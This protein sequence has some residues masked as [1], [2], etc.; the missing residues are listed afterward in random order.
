[1]SFVLA[2]LGGSFRLLARAVLPLALL[3]ILSACGGSTAPEPSETKA[4][5]GPGF[6]FDVPVGWKVHRSGD[7]VDAH[8]G[9]ALVSVTTYKLLKA[10]DPA[11]FD[12]AAE[13]LDAAV[14]KLAK[15]AK[16][17]VVEKKTTEVAG[18]KIRDYRYVAKGFATRL[19]FVF[20][21][22]REWQLLCRARAEDDD[23]D[24]A[25]KLLFDSFSVG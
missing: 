14:A 16:G 7:A 21:G 10:Y 19:G 24:G 15:Q 20:E 25:C 9:S 1:L 2:I 3:F 22:K 12:R 11:V 17:T 8:N 4:V 13:E 5:P 23:P 6:R 18:R